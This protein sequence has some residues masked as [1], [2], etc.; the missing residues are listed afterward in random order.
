VPHEGQN[1]ACGGASAPQEGQRRASAVPHDAQNRA[2]S[3][4]V[5]WQFGQGVATGASLAAPSS[6]PAHDAVMRQSPALVARTV[7]V[8]SG[9]SP[10]PRATTTGISMP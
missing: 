9:S 7:T 10:A 5:A 2:P 6:G 1:R 3:G 4:F 8:L